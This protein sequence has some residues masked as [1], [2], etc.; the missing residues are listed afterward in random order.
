MGFLTPI[1]RTSMR[2]LLLLSAPLPALIIGVLVM[3]RSGV[4]S[5]IW[6]QQI[7]AGLTLTALCAAVSL[8]PRL[9][10]PLG[11]QGVEILALV[12]LLLLA[13]TLAQPGLEG[14]RRWV[15]VGPLQWHSAFVT[16]PVLLVLFG[17]ILEACPFR[18][19]AW[20]IPLATTVA[21]TVLVLQP[22]PSQL[23]AFG[24]A[25]V[26]QLFV[27]RSRT[28]SDWVTAGVILPAAIVAW[29]RP[30]PLAPV[31]Y[32]E[33]IVGRAGTLGTVWVLASLLALALLSLPFIA[34]AVQLRSSH[35][36][37]T[38]LA[39][40]V[41]FAIVSSMP[42]FGPYPV[43]IL[44]Y[45]ISPMV[46]YFAVLGWL[47]LKSPANEPTRTTSRESSKLRHNEV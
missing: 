38:S 3:Q 23:T 6:G 47:V 32:V 42:L 18:T 24:V 10:R 39:V 7:A 26:V 16:L 31:P 14:V 22:D 41:Y 44:G 12:V 28:S 8:A 13:A 34:H 36:G 30:D 37:R 21:A 25:V 19:G 45:G 2:R 20:S 9:R 15:S 46:G 43:P 17:K 4:S 11:F 1:S 40:A 27:R 5:G 33:G 35:G 29:T